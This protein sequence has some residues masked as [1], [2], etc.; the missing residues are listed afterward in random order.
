MV[1]KIQVYSF[2]VTIEM[3]KVR[4]SVDIS[5]SKVILGV[6]SVTATVGALQYFKSKH[7]KSGKFVKSESKFSDCKENENE[8]KRNKESVK[9]KCDANS[10][11]YNSTND[12]VKNKNKE[13]AKSFDEVSKHDTSYKFQTSF[14]TAN[15]LDKKADLSTDDLVS[16]GELNEN[17]QTEF[18]EKRDKLVQPNVSLSAIPKTIHSSSESSINKQKQQTKNEDIS[19]QADETETSVNCNKLGSETSIGINRPSADCRDS[20]TKIEEISA[21]TEQENNQRKDHDKRIAHQEHTVNKIGVDLDRIKDLLKNSKKRFDAFLKFVVDEK[22][23]LESDLES[24][25]S[26][27]KSNEKSI[28]RS[29]ND[30]FCKRVDDVNA[31]IDAQKVQGSISQFFF[32]SLGHRANIMERRCNKYNESK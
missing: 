7:K 15:S 14:A 23:A 29:I 19:T 20:A 26:S 16:A 1:F 30:K 11:G 24:I 5:L 3:I 12:R 13:S 9:Q 6:A 27:Y 4:L 2:I 8:A 31:K 17:T 10:M 22:E 25:A 18:I 32:T 28:I 21:A